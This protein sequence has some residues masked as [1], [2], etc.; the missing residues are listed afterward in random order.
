[1]VSTVIV[2]S[3]TVGSITVV[4]FG[5]FACV[6]TFLRHRKYGSDSTEFFLTARRSVVRRRRLVACLLSTHSA[7]SAHPLVSISGHLGACISVC[8]LHKC[9]RG[10]LHLPAAW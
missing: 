3:Y 1:M 4:L 8:M 7:C 9:R 6:Y 10:W 5:T 2:A